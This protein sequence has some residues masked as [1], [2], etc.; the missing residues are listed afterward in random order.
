MSKL[1]QLGLTGSIT[2]MGKSATLALFAEMGA[3]IYDADA[4]VHKLYASA[5]RRPW[6]KPASAW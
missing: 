5:A 2:G 4:T 1:I 3:A 6:S